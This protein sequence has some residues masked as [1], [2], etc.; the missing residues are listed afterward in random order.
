MVVP[1]RRDSTTLNGSLRIKGSCSVL[2]TELLGTQ[3]LHPTELVV[4][5]NYPVEVS[6]LPAMTAKRTVTG[7][8]EFVK[9][10]LLVRLQMALIDGNNLTKAN[11]K[12]AYS[13]LKVCS[14]VVTHFFWHV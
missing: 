9:E 6:W 11:N 1:R 4:D 8:C 3:R 13:R 12:N 10:P 5:L 7:T 2:I 14:S